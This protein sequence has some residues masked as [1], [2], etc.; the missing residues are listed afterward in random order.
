MSYNNA[1]YLFMY[2]FYS[3]YHW[4]MFSPEMQMSYIFM[5]LWCWKQFFCFSTVVYLTIK[6]NIFDFH[7]C[8]VSLTHEKQTSLSCIIYHCQQPDNLQLRVWPE[9]DFCRRSLI[10]MYDELDMK[11]IFFLFSYDLHPKLDWL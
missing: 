2:W 5:Y 11:Q 9:N 8:K 7:F 4:A 1:I 6:T 3:F 10:M